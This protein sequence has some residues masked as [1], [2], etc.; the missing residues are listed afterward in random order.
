VICL[1]CR[2][3]RVR[4]TVNALGLSVCCCYLALS[5]VDKY[6]ADRVFAEAL[7]DRQ[8]PA[9]RFMAAPTPLNNVLWYCLA[10][11]DNGYWTGYYSLLDRGRPPDWKFIR[12]NGQLLAGVRDTE[13][14]ARLIWFSDGYYAVRVERGRLIFDVLKFGG[15]PV[16]PDGEEQ[17]AFSF[18]IERGPGGELQATNLMRRRNVDFPR[19]AAALWKRIWGRLG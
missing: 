13:L 3:E 12:R 17:A 16:G 18:A 9:T 6:R 15:F 4:R 5:F 19:A 8:I 10:E 14:I 11:T 2:R 7:A 1:L